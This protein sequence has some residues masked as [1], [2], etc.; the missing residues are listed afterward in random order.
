[1]L[2]EVASYFIVALCQV[3]LLLH[4]PSSFSYQIP[5]KSEDIELGVLTSL[6]DDLNLFLF[7]EEEFSLAGW[8]DNVDCFFQ[9][10]C[11]CIHLHI[12]SLFCLTALMKMYLKH[13]QSIL[14]A[15]KMHPFPYFN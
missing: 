9:V 4:L 12:F 5:E 11:N 14:P 15:G 2:G 6:F 8:F 13:I 10:G 3:V 1:M 7:S